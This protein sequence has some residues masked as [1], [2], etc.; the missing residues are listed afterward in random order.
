M[1]NNYLIEVFDRNGK[2]FRK[3]DRPYVLVPFTDKDAAD[4]IAGFDRGREQDKVF[5]DMAKDVPF[6]KVKTVTERML[7][8]DNGNLWIQTNE[9]KEQDGKSYTAY[10]IFNKDGLY[11]ARIW[12]DVTPGLFANGKMYRRHTDKETEVVSIKR[13]RIIWE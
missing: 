13:Y 6:P 9:E 4:Y 3:F 2:L 12:S 7:V 8:D 11:D 5:V 1:N 10:D